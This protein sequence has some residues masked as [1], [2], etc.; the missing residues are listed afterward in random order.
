[1]NCAECGKELTGKHKSKYCSRDCMWV[2][3]R[4]ERA[5]ASE[6]KRTRICETCG[7]EFVMPY[8]SGK[9]KRGEIQSGLYCSRKC[10]WDAIR[11]PEIKKVWHCKVCGNEMSVYA[12]YCSDRC[13]KEKANRESFNR[14]KSKKVLKARPCNECGK[15]FIPEYGNKRRM[16]CSKECLSKSMRRIRKHKDRARLKMVKVESVDPMK[17]FIRDGWR[18]QLCGKKLKRPDRGT[19][20][21]CAPELDHIVPLSKGGEHS[22]QNTQCACRKCNGD[23]AGEERGQLRLFG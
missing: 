12:V 7:K 21:D 9:A 11:K 14:S 6:A 10:R 13:R 3:Q 17:V 5:I 22:Y 20:K 19:Y 2:Y 18:C 1:M 23:K 16:F 4:R 15:L 8:M